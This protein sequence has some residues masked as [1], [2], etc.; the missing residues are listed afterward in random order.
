MTLLGEHSPSSHAPKPFHRLP[1][2]EFSSRYFLGGCGFAAFVTA[3]AVWMPTPGQLFASTPKPN[4]V[5]TASTEAAQ[6]V[7][8]SSLEGL[9]AASQQQVTVREGDGP[10]QVAEHYIDDEVL[11]SSNTLRDTVIAY[12]ARQEADGF[13]PGDT[14]CL[15]VLSHQQEVYMDATEQSPAA[16][17][18]S[19]C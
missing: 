1:R 18:F 10:A 8:Y 19:H 11:N 3:A 13:Q 6:V 14:I 16:Q 2:P 17:D 15:P 9:S 12:I 4:R 5:A 7:D